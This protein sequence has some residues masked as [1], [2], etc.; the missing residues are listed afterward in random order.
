MPHRAT[1]LAVHEADFHF[2]DAS[3]ALEPLRL[4]HLMQEE[5]DPLSDCIGRQDIERQTGNVARLL[6]PQI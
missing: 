2:A 1:H 3:L 6:D 5:G 4:A